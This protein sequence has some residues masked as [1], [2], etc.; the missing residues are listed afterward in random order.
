MVDVHIHVSTF[1]LALPRPRHL[2]IKFIPQETLT[3]CWEK[4]VLL[5]LAFYVSELV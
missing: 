5:Q 4:N 1:Q 3:Y 2:C